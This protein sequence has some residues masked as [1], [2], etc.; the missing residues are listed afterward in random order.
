MIFVLLWGKFSLG[1]IYYRKDRIN[2]LNT[3]LNIIPITENMYWED[4]P[5]NTN[6]NMLTLNNKSSEH[7]YRKDNIYDI[8]VVIKYNVKPVTPEKVVQYLFILLKNII[9]QLKVA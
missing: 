9:F 4:N 7:L 5:Y 6:Y 1:P 3:K 2:K 8:L